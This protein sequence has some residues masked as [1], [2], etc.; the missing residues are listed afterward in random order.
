VKIKQVTTT[1]IIRVKIDDDWKRFPVLYGKTGRVVPGL[2]IW[3]KKELTFKDVSYEIRYYKG[4]KVC[5]VPAGKNASDAEAKRLTL[6]NQLSAKAIAQA[7]GIPVADPT[8]RKLIKA[9]ADEYINKRSVFIGHDQLMRIKYVIVLF[10]RSCSKTYL[11]EITANDILNFLRLLAT[12]P[13]YD[14]ARRKPSK[15][16]LAGQ[17]RRRLPSAPRTISKRSIFSYFISARAWLCDGG[18]DRN[19]FPSPPKYEEVEVT[20]YSPEEISTFVSLVQGNLRIATLL[21]LKCGLRRQEVAHAYF[22]DINFSDKTILV[23]GKPEFNFKVKNYSQRY[24]PV[25]DDL[26]E[27][28]RQWQQDHSGQML[29]VQTAKGTPD[30]RMIRSL[31][32]F[33]YLHGLRCGRCEHCRSGHPE[34]EEWELHKFRRTYITAIVRHVDLRTA[35]A[36]A[37]HKRIASTERYLKAASAS[38]GQKRVSAIDWTK[39]FYD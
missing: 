30:L 1:L 19:I 32:R 34:C 15:R 21:M 27:E 29:I 12:L 6:Q 33:A 4:R 28:L 11:D 16:V 20:V 7:A 35:Q 38:Q 18:V 17:A 22:S 3:H 13:V 26:I 14:P 31:K 8:E 37:G 5:Y 39:P 25:P 36:Y 23:R 2:V 9:W 10:L 24:V